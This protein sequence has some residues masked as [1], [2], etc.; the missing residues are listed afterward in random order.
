MSSLWGLGASEFGVSP[1]I[2]SKHGVIGL[3][4]TAALEYAKNNIRVNA[5]CP[6]WVHTP[7]NDA[8]LQNPEF[9]QQ[10]EAHHPINRLGKES[11]I[12][13]AVLWLAS[14][15]AGFFTGHS[16]VLDGGISARR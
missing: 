11:E 1:Y 12:A 16:M 6:G 5:V 10:I 3:T 4:E 8:V 7:A 15:G 13:S 2:S 14:A 9:R